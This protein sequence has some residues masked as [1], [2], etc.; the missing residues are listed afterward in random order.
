MS[1]GT[2]TRSILFVEDYLRKSTDILRRIPASETAALIELLREARSARQRLFVCGN[3][4]SAATA[5]HF[6]AGLGKEASSNGSGRFRA[7]A[8]TDNVPWMTSLANDVDYASVFVEQLINHAE[9]G[10]VLIAFSGSG[11]SSNILRAVEWANLNGLVTIGITSRPE[12]SLGRAAHH[13]LCIDSDHIGH[14]EE[15]HFLVQHLITYY[16]RDAEE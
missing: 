7:M 11:N 16:F 12:S 5:S 14:V 10:D 9:S 4:G 8:L 2:G 3:G 13:L 15:A 6:A 1:E